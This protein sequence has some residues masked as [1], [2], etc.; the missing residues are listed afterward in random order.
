MD[1]RARFEEFARLATEQRNP[2]TMDL[3]TLEVT[4]LLARISA[5]DRT[6]PDAVAKELPHIARA[7]DYI[8]ASFKSGGRLVY[9]G[10]GT[11]GRLGVLDA[12]ECPPTFGSEPDQVVGVIA[13]G[14]TAVVRAVEGAED[15]ADQGAQAMDDLEV[16]PEDTVVG[17]AASRR[18]PYVVS[19]IARARS[20]G[21]RTV[22]VTCTP[23]EEFTLDVDVAICPVVGPE[24]LMGSTRMKAGTAQKLV[25][26]MLSTASFVRIGKVYENMMVDLLANSQKLVER[27]RRTVMTATGCDYTTAS[28][29]ID[30][31][32]KSVKVAIV[33]MKAGV[34]RAEAERRLTEADGFV[35]RALEAG[36]AA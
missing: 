9:V 34:S 3:D 25:C 31:A 15:R 26:N 20:L 8:V 16:G 17:L 12:S 30:A 32:G 22:Y 28:H 33:M 24:V 1:D 10:A 5:E 36:P 27:G 35:R 2:R 13:G 7:V 6:V 4:E 14:Y 21:A 23:R 29:A 18:T 11:S 19:A